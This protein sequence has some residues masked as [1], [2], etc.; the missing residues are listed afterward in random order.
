MAKNTGIPANL[1]HMLLKENCDHL[2]CTNCWSEFC[3]L[4]RNWLQAAE[5]A[6][7]VCKG[8]VGI[9]EQKTNLKKTQD[10]FSNISLTPKKTNRKKFRLFSTGSEK[11]PVQ[12]K[13]FLAKMKKFHTRFSSE[14]P[15]DASQVA[16]RHRNKLCVEHGGVLEFWC[17]DCYLV[18]CKKCL[19]KNHRAC[20]WLLLENG[21]EDIFSWTNPEESFWGDKSLFALSQLTSSLISR[22]RGYSRVIKTFK[23]DMEDCEEQL[24]MKYNKLKH[25]SANLENLIGNTDYGSKEKIFE[26]CK[27]LEK[28]MYLFQEPRELIWRTAKA[29]QVM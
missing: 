4:D 27:E 21:P 29:Y 1:S 26:E 18:M 14:Q 15:S 6:A 24:E 7:S 25:L 17:N 3:S 10:T 22:V 5:N 9:D 19:D 16:M 13:N 2:R 8:I 20:D 28:L 23:S 12:E 11:P